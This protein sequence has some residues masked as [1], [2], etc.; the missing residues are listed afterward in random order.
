MIRNSKGYRALYQRAK[1][2]GAIRGC[3]Q[4]V[5]SQGVMYVHEFIHI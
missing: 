2:Q 1:A 5:S 3:Y 4:R